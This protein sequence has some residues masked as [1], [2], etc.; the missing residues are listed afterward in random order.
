MR[1]TLLPALLLVFA[2]PASYGLAQETA[3]DPGE[4]SVADADIVVDELDRGTPRRSLVGFLTVAQDRDFEKAAEYLDLRNLPSRVKSF[5]G[6][7]LAQ[8]LSIIIERQLWIDF[9][10]ISDDPDGAGGDGLPS[11]RDRFAEIE[12]EGKVITLL[13]QRV[14]RGDGEFI[15]KISN[16]TVA[17]I[18]DLYEVFGYG[19]VEEY[20]IGVLPDITILNIELFKW[21]I[22]LGAALI[23]YPILRVLLG[24]L[25]GVLVKQSSPVREAVHR[26]LTR[27]FLWLV[28]IMITNR[29]TASLGLGIEAQKIESAHT[30][31]III[32]TWVL[33]SVTNLFRDIYRMRLQ[34]LG[35]EGAIVLLGPIGNAMKGL[36][37]VLAF[38]LWLNNLG[39]NI[40]ALLAGLG[41]GGIA[42]ALALQKPLE[43]LFGAVTLYTQQPAKVGDFCKFGTI[44]GTI[45]EIGLRT[46]RIRTLGNT[47]VSIPNAKVAADV[48]D[49]YSARSRI[50]YH[51]KL[52]LRYDSTPAQ[53]NEVLGESRKLLEKNEKV[54]D[55]PLRVRLTGFGRQGIELDVYAYISTSDYAEFLETAEELNLAIVEIVAKSGT[56]FAVPVQLLDTDR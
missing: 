41:V 28:L 54:E 13:L 15:W 4:Q 36:F 55:E 27:P 3:P 35:R 32:V 16:K 17:E 2:L 25:A 30:V 7:K 50:W 23:A 5:D 53:L 18:P 42:V 44:T 6:A 11:Y 19:R 12:S 31:D 52:T 40:T 14:P 37:V 10:E 22:L 38:L 1:V 56:A 49:N 34:R 47:V 45:E 21:V 29:V 43:D 8:G 33:L 24:F 39:F 46:T 26:F 9:A 51:P 48:L 20:L